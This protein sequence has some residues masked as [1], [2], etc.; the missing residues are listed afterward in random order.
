MLSITHLLHTLNT[1][2]DPLTHSLISSV[3]GVGLRVERCEEWG[4]SAWTNLFGVKL[5]EK[6]PACPEYEQKQPEFEQKQPRI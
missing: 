6:P 4:E 3:R 2:S 5:V 1:H